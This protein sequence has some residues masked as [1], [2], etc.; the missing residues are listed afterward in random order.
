MRMEEQSTSN[1][2]TAIIQIQ[3]LL[4]CV[5]FKFMEKIFLTFNTLNHDISF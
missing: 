3:G 2:R 5:F 1:K 4:T